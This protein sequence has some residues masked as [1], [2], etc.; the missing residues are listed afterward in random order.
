RPGCL[1]FVRLFAFSGDTGGSGSHSDSAS[2]SAA[3]TPGS[4]SSNS[5][6]SSLSAS[7]FGP[8]LRII[9]KRRRSSSVWIF[10]RDHSSS[11]VN[12]TICSA[13]ERGE[14]EGEGLTEGYSRIADLHAD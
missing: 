4:S 13:S 5:N 1:P 3:L 12:S 14:V 8:Y 7:L 10:N 9:S 11:F 2:T 6:C